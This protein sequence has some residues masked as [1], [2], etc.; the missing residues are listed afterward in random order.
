[1]HVT[2]KT[3]CDSPTNICIHT[4]FLSSQM[5]NATDDLYMPYTIIYLHIILSFCTWQ[6]LKYD[7]TSEE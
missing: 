7:H 5:R 6:I 1:M 4:L 3:H 2:F